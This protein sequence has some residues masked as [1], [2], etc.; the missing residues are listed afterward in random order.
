ME[1]GGEGEELF[2]V[3]KETIAGAHRKPKWVLHYNA[4]ADSGACSG[5]SGC[6]ASAQALLRLTQAL[7]R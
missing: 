7:I 5:C 6:S 4:Q 2:V 3:S 1:F